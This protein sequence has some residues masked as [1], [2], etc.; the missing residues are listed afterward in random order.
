MGDGVL[1]YFGYP[2][3]DEA[4]AERAIRAGLTIVDAVA[5]L[6]TV[7][8]PPARSRSASASIA[9]SWSWAI[10]S[11]P[12]PR[13][14]TAVVGDTPNLAARLQTA[15]EPGTIVISDATRLLV[16]SLFEYRELD[17]VQPE[18]TSRDRARLGGAGRKRAS[19]AATRRC[20]AAS[21]RW[22]TAPRSLNCCCAAGSRP[23]AA[24]AAS[25]CST[26]EPGI[27]K[28]RLDCR[29]GAIRRHRTPHLRLRFLCSPHHL[30][31][32]LYP[33]IRHI[34]RAANFQRG[35]PPAAKWDKLDERRFPLALPRR[36]RRCWRTC[37]RSRAPLRTCSRTVTPQRRKAMT[38]A[39]IIRQIEKLGP[40]EADPCRSWRTCIG[41]TPRRSSCSIVWSRPSSSCR[42]CSSSPRVPKCDPAWA[43]RPHVTVQLL[44]GLDRRTAAVAHQTGCRRA[45]ASP[46]GHRSHHRARRQRAALHRGA[47]Q[48]G[49]RAGRQT[50]TRGEPASPIESLSVDAGS[51]VAAFLAHGAARSTSGRQG[52]RPD[53]S[54]HWPGIFIRDDAGA[55][56]AAGQAVWSMRSPSSR[57][58]K[59][60]SRTV[61]RRS[62]PTPSSTRWCRTPPTRRC[63][64]TGAARS[65][66]ASPRN[67]RRTPPARRRNRS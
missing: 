65:I 2:Q 60:S 50:T 57:R 27:G 42:C 17:I 67:W 11:A 32:P 5:R 48:D 58:L 23:R 54:G 40:A 7:A 14:E 21:C 64:A 66:C 46:G 9:G 16:G 29:A 55:V 36:T 39:A 26:G 45:R 47:D 49:S 25:C 34:E 24:K 33:I 44:S 56:A 53:R 15:A 38:F 28:S 35:R 62:P 37:F 30:D 22:S 31:T 61:S 63:C 43:A 41:R 13:S 20:A 6:D 8:G 10:S 3:A 18:R 1:V 51:D 4:D 12:D 52:D 59:S 19:T